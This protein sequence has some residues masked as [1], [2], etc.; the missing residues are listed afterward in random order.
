[1]KDKLVSIII[2]TY[3]R[4]HFL[5]DT[6]NSILDQSYKYWECIV[7][8]DHSEDD[9]DKLMTK[10]VK[11]DSRFIYK[12]RPDYLAKGANSCRNYGFE[13]S[14]G[15]YINWFDSDDI[16]L[17]KHLEIL[18][19]NL[20]AKSLDFVVGDSANFINLEKGTSGKPYQLD[21]SPVE[22]SAR[23]FA[24][25]RIGWIT[26]D[27]LGKR[28]T[29]MNTKFN[30]R[31]RT[32]GDE[33]NF[34][35]RYLLKGYKGEFVNEVLSYHRIHEN[36]LS[37]PELYDTARTYFKVS[38]IKYLTFLDIRNLG[39]IELKK[40]F[41]KGYMLNS[42]RMAKYKK[43]PFKLVSSVF[44][45]FKYYPMQKAIAYFGSIFLALILN[46]GYNLLKYAR[47]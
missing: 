27:F 3:N 43:V 9:T 32:D 17:P 39:D 2:P 42:F 11:Q 41:L 15:E 36:T 38:Q 25:Q 44:Y 23:D 13:L 7:I 16:M 19:E 37:N 6:L 22:I 18:V 24:Q 10:V 12:R 1:M 21:R 14:K 26:D 31:I 46:K 34:F 8:D 28:N 29:L 5:P 20:E 30:T 45:I 47:Q 33:Y 40:W 4:S 35:T